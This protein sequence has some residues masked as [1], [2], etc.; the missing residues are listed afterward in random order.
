MYCI[1]RSTAA[2]RAFGSTG[3]L[4]THKS[5]R[6]P[7]E[8]LGFPLET[9]VGSQCSLRSRNRVGQGLCSAELDTWQGPFQVML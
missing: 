7:E 3:T 9:A 6:G 4:V 2:K 1:M 5:F 8:G